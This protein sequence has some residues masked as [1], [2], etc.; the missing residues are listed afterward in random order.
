MPPPRIVAGMAM[1]L[2]GE[3]PQHAEHPGHVL[4]KAY[5]DIWVLAGD[6]QVKPLVDSPTA[7]KA[8]NRH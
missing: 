4:Y 3:G 6:A 8:A 2:G 7:T 5:M 1:A